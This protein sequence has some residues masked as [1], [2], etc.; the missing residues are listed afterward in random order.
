MKYYR[1]LA[2]SQG[3]HQAYLYPLRFHLTVEQDDP[4]WSNYD[5]FEAQL[6]SGTTI[7]S[8]TIVD[9]LIFNV[10]VWGQTDFGY[11]DVVDLDLGVFLDG[12]GE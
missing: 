7:Y 8:R 6:A 5:T 4:D 2:I 12:S 1:A 10:H 9:C 11:K 3:T